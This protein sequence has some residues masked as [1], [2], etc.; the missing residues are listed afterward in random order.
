MNLKELA[1]KLD[2]STTTVSRALG[3]YSEVN[4]QTRERVVA[5]ARKYNYQPNS[6]AKYLATGRAMAVAEVIPL[7]SRSAIVN[8]I[9]AD[10]MVGAG[11][12]F[13]R[14]GYDI[15]LSIVA[16]EGED[17]T[18]RALAS[19]R[20]ADGVILHGPRLDDHRIRLLNDLGLPFVVHGR[21]GPDH[22]PDSY[23]WIDVNNYDSF[24]RATNVLLD[25]GHR[26]IALVNGDE[27]LNF[28]V[29]RRAGFVDAL[30]ARGL[31]PD[32]ALMLSGEMTLGL[33]YQAARHLL[34]RP[35][36][37]SAILSSSIMLALG[38]ERA[39]VE[40]GLTLGRDLSLVTF[41]DRLSYADNGGD[42]PYFTAVGSSVREAGAK[43]AT[44]LLKRIDD[45]QAPHES[46]RL[47]SRIVI[48]RSTGPANI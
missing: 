13:S 37:P 7:S 25:L 4:E 10:F 29:R 5:A 32:P 27:T 31:S 12:V 17:D 20:P 34:S 41:D 1:E 36:R 47:E 30:A 8:P 6:R 43:T 19:Q 14:N 40:A 35:E 44:L 46:T 48:G 16:D 18:Y 22:A 28:A 33:G 21:A 11:E 15:T 26:R 3:G 39:A 23:S 38:I 9:Y 42:S 2:L 45:P 24:L